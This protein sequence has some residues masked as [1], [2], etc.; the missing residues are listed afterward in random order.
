MDALLPRL[1]S[2]AEIAAHVPGIEPVRASEQRPFWSIMLPSY[3]CDGYLARALASVLAQD[4]GAAAM[5]IEVI[6][7]G[8]T[9][10]DPEALASRLGGARV[11]FQRHPRNLGATETFNTCLRRARGR[12]VHILHADD[13][14]LPGFYAAYRRVI[15]SRDD[16]AMVIGPVTSIDEHGER[17]RVLGPDPPADGC[18]LADFSHQQATRQLVQFAGWVMRREALERG[19]GFC[20]LF[21]HCADWELAF[22]IG[23][24]GTVGCV[25]Q[26]YG[27]Y[28]MHSASDT[29]RLMRTGE[30][31]REATLAIR[32]NLRRLA[33][34][35]RGVS[36]RSWRSRL[37][38]AA[39]DSA[40]ALAAEGSSEGRLAQ[41]RWAFVLRPTLRRALSFA[42]AWFSHALAAP[43]ARVAPRA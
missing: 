13:E 31:I 21:H 26:A 14:V 32:L 30:N 42:R 37:A 4:E 7:D 43:R 18:V 27:L 35:N 17:G 19:G 8:S 15:E 23:L 16:L 5:Q 36:D 2:E 28:R 3:D 6:D 1:P 34:E 40:R 10:G 25:P 39:G 12:W 20:T 33:Q 9:R 11:G 29:R 38:R 22:R 24:H 41:A